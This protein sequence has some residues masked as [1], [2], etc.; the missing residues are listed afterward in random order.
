[1]RK[2]SKR[3]NPTRVCMLQGGPCFVLCGMCCLSTC[4]LVHLWL[5][6]FPCV[7]VG[8]WLVGL[9]VCPGGSAVLFS[10]ESRKRRWARECVGG[11]GVWVSKRGVCTSSAND[12][13]LVLAHEL[14]G[15][16]GHDLNMNEGMGC[17]GMEDG[18][19]TGE[20]KDGDGGGR[21]GDDGEREEVCAREGEKKKRREKRDERRPRADF[22]S[23]VFPLR[24]V[25]RACLPPSSSCVS[26][27][28]PT[29][30]QRAWLVPGV[31]LSLFPAHCS[32]THSP[33]W[34]L[35]L[36]PPP[37]PSSFSFSF[38]FIL[39]HPHPLLITTTR[40]PCSVLLGGMGFGGKLFFLCRCVKGRQ[41]RSNFEQTAKMKKL[42]AWALVAFPFSFIHSFIHTDSNAATTT[43]SQ[44]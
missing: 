17:E 6:W 7:A 21:R 40:H 19:R 31:F 27:C 43:H 24:W 23:L 44:S 38:S 14:V 41:K 13:E 42:S 2:M 12:D 30:S 22:F 25:G 4:P 11:G 39:I 20:R 28:A 8:G 35:S 36:P 33:A 15:L 9:S 1:V 5:L 3:W 37:P 32:L 16:L 26:A 34:S 29:R 10:Q 18:A